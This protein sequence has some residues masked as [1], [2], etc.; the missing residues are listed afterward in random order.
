M[1]EPDQPSCRTLI[2][3]EFEPV[4]VAKEQFRLEDSLADLAIL[5][6]VVGFKDEVE[7]LQF[8]DNYQDFR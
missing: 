8:W 6:K 4:K 3:K 2:Q 1:S 5:Y 7:N